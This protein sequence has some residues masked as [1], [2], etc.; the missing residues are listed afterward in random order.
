M[1]YIHL[2]TWLVFLLLPCSLSLAGEIGCS[3]TVAVI[4]ADHHSCTDETGK[5]QLAFKLSSGGGNWLCSGSDGSSALVL[6]AKMSDKN[7]SVYISDDG[8]ATCQSHANYLK[9]S[10]I[11]LP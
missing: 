4:M 6:S 7:I 3:G 10:Y 5:K 8:G 9:P 11:V 1:K 2:I